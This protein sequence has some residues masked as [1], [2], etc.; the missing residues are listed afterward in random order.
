ME[1][2]ANGDL[3]EKEFSLNFT[4]NLLSFLSYDY[5]LDISLRCISKWTAK[6]SAFPLTYFVALDKTSKI[7]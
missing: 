4:I 5:D 7:G 2:E 6:G 3:P 1:V